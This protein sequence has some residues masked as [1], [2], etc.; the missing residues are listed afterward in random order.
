MKP[1]EH[2]GSKTWSPT[3]NLCFSFVGMDQ[4]KWQEKTPKKETKTQSQKKKTRQKTK[5]NKKKSKT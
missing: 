1:Q 5:I 3:G 2:T 4:C